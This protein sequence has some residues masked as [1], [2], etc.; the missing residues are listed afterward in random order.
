M[1]SS[2]IISSRWT[3]FS[4]FFSELLIE[5]RMLRINLCGWTILCRVLSRNL[6]PFRDF[7]INA[8]SGLF[9]LS[10]L[11]RRSIFPSEITVCFISSDIGNSSGVPRL[12]SGGF[13]SSMGPPCFRCVFI[14]ANR[15]P[16]PAAFLANVCDCT[17]SFLLVNIF[18]NMTWRATFLKLRVS[19]VIFSFVAAIVLFLGKRLLASIFAS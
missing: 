7:S 5:D 4:I 17:F 14:V 1:S 2:L 9:C 12:L 19:F 8:S 16:R 13:S 11:G 10:L 3:P 18:A 6:L 15:S